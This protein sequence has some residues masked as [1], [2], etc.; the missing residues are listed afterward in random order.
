MLPLPP[1]RP[2]VRHGH[3][4]CTVLISKKKA[5]FAGGP[6]FPRAVYLPVGFLRGEFLTGWGFDGVG[7]GDIL[8]KRIPVTEA[9]EPVEELHPVDTVLTSWHLP[10]IT[11]S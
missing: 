3:S 8:Y 10:D 6:C 11:T 9:R 5:A 1:K 4:H 2:L 7:Q